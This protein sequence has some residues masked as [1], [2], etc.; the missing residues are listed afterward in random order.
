[1]DIEEPALA[2]PT[3]AVEVGTM[4]VGEK[5]RRRK[6][7]REIALRQVLPE[8]IIIEQGMS[9]ME[10]RRNLQYEEDAADSEGEVEEI[11]ER[12]AMSESGGEGEGGREQEAVAPGLKSF[13]KL[14]K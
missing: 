12:C 1:M 5:P 9:L 7:A 6:K 4:S 8:S 10:A 2:V 3:E 11:D 14:T 13:P